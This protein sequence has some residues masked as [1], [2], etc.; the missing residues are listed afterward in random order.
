[1]NLLEALDTIKAA[2]ELAQLREYYSRTYTR[3]IAQEP[4]GPAE[5]G[6]DEQARDIARG[7]CEITKATA[8]N[9]E[10]RERYDRHPR[11]DDVHETMITTGGHLFTITRTVPAGTENEMWVL[12]ID[13]EPIPHRV[14][15]SEVPHATD[16]ILRSFWR[17]RR[18][19]T[20]DPCDR[21]MCDNPPTVAMFRQSLCASCAAKLY[22]LS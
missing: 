15:T 1:V 5:C 18:G 16:M 7:L 8:W 12:A 21:L 4:T 10:T 19:I 2:D 6:A 11:V 22:P 13:G 17:H 9:A 20:V 3:T 14:F